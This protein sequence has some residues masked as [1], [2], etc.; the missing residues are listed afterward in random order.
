LR[1]AEMEISAAPWALEAQ[2]VLFANIG[3]KT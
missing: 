3:F 1:A 2:E